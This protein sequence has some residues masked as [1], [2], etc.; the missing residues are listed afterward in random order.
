MR[1][2]QTP[3]KRQLLDPILPLINVV[4]LLLIF[5]MMMS[6]VEGTDGYDVS[7]PTSTSDDPAGSREMVLVLTEDGSIELDGAIMSDSALMQYAR[8]QKRDQLNDIIKIKADADVDAIKLIAL[9]ENL[10]K[11]GIENLVLLTEKGN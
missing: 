4:F 8:D 11:G 7:P 10:R 5:V 6:R 2:P 9:M 1:F 3:K